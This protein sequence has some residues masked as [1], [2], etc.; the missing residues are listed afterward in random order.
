MVEIRASGVCHTDHKILARRPPQVMGHEGAG[1]VL[2]VGAEVDGIRAGQHVVLNWAMPCLRCPACLRGLTNVCMAKPE[3]RPGTFKVNGEAVG[4]SFGLATMSRVTVVPAAAVVPIAA[5]MPSE[6]A[7]LLGCCVM[8]GYGS[9]VNAAKVEAGASVVV[10]GTGAVGL[11]VVQSARIAGAGQ[12]I[13][14]D[15]SEV[16][17]EAARRYGATHTV[18]VQRDDSELQAAMKKVRELTLG[19]GSDYA[20]ECT[21][22]P[23]LGLSP[24]A[25]VR[26]GGTALQL[27]GIEERV[28]V[29]MELFEWDKIYMNPLY[30]KCLPQRDFPKLVN[31]WRRGELELGS[32]ITTRFPLSDLSEAFD[33]MLAGKLLKGVLT[34]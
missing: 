14:L 7:C 19:L 17:L 3:V 2:K 6:Q 18:L 12:I 27:S 23:A 8:T 5:E 13:A 16:K 29:D 25:M 30:G 10:I 22:V 33:A 26:H 11:C 15:V 34:F 31:H 20:F 32:L 24:L 4:A 28:T 1:I 9:V 21:S